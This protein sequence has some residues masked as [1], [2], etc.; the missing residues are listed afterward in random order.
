[1]TN[2]A[3]IQE[4]NEQ[5]ILSGEPDEIIQESIKEMVTSLMHSK[6]LILIIN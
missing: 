6:N 5:L 2:I 3:V 1:M 4:N